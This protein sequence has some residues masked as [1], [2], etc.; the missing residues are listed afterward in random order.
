MF[1]FCDLRRGEAMK[2]AIMRCWRG[3]PAAASAAQMMV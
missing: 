2:I 3:K 1:I